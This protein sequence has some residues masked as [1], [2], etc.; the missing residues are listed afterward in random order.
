MRFEE[1]E[2]D[3]DEDLGPRGRAAAAARVGIDQEG[4][5]ETDAQFEDSGGF[6]AFREL[7]VD[8]FYYKK[9]IG[10]GIK[11]KTPPVAVLTDHVDP[12]F[13]PK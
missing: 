5:F 3:V 6:E 1:D 13:E 2:V 4:F 7:L 9:H 11:W 10:G 12:R 8:H